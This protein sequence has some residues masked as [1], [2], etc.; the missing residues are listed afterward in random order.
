[1]TVALVVVIAALIVERVWSQH[2]HARE[3]RHLTNAV[4]AKHGSEL[5]ALDHEPR[6]PDEE[7][8]RERERAYRLDN[9]VGY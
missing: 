1:M 2:V 8:I 3:R 4:I 6:R 5:L 7:R 9:P